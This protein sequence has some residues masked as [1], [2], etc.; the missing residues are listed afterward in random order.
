MTTSLSVPS[1][2]EL[3]GRARSLQ[4]LLRRYS[5][6]GEINRLLADE[7]I[8]ALTGAGLFRLFTPRRFGGYAIS[9]RTLA[10]VTEAL[11]E[12]DGSAAWVVQIAAGGAW[13]AAHANARAQEEVFGENPDARLAS[14]NSPVP[15]QR[16]EGGVR[17]DGRWSYASG[18]P[19]ADWAGI[20]IAA[21]AD[22][23][24]AEAYFALVPRSDIGIEDTWRTV[25]VRATGSHTWCS[26]GLFVPEHRLLSV[27]ALAAGVPQHDE[28]LYRLPSAPVVTLNLMGTLLGLGSAAL[29][30]TIEKS[31]SKAVSY[32]VYTRQS[33]SVAVQT[34]IAEA[35]LKIDTARLHIYATADKLDAAAR[36][37]T[38]I[39]Y[40]TRARM[41][42]SSGHATREVL[43]AIQLLLNVHGS[44]SFAESNPLQRIWR[45]ANTA[46]RHAGLNTA[47]GYEVLG[48][49]LLD[50]PQRITP[51]V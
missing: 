48:K 6:D 26:E 42:A 2:E 18:A 37:S 28:A 7:V 39:D 27:A 36:T 9:L 44:G 35:A 3:V 13:G 43:D 45:D 20:G 47:V 11:A 12:A 1:H 34:Q 32:T 16:V 14:S 17:V 30:H 51:M 25:G 50:I 23:G 41:R 49:M 24:E 4:P 22:N 15:A 21:P 29:N 5:A 40:A 38:T 46:G 33:D 19:H 8:D 31:V 10:E